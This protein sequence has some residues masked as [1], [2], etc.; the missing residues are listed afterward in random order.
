[1]NVLELYQQWL[2]KTENNP[3]IYDELLAVKDDEKAI[4]DRFYKGLAFGTGGLRGVIGAGT[5][6]MN[7]Y[8]VGKA[9]LG[10]ADY[11]LENANGKSVGVAIAY[12]S[13]NMSKEFAY[14]AAQILS[15]KGIKAYLFAELTPTPVLSFAVRY[16]KADAGI[17]I[18]ASH[19]PKEY[20]GYKVYNELGCQITDGAA[21]AI[22]ACIEKH[23]YFDEYTPNESL[24]VYL[25][26]DV[27]R[28]FLDAIKA[29][30]ISEITAEN[31]PSVVYSPLHGTGR[32]Y[33]QAILKELG[34]TS[35][36][37]VAEQEEP[38]GNFTT[39]PY[40]NPE[41]KAALTL[42]LRDAEIYKPDL[43]MA[44]DPDADRIGIAV[45]N[46]KGEYVLL[47]GN[48]TGSILLYYILSRKREMG[49]LGATPTVI[50]TIV[51]TDI[52]FDMAKEF[53]AEV[54]E[55]LTGF[56]YIGEALENTDNYVLGL[57]ES[58]GYLVGTHARDKDA[59]SA[60]MLIVEACAYFKG[61]GKSLFAVLNEIYEKYGYYRTDLFSISLPGKD[62]MEKM[63]EMLVKIRK[64][65]EKAF[66]GKD[67][68]FAD[69]AKGLFGLPKSDVLRFVNDTY[70]VLIRPSGTEPK[71]KV[72]LQV[73]GNSPADADEKLARIRT[74]VK[75]DWIGV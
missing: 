46:E 71:M 2:K 41:E 11:L 60:A 74:A 51:T 68:T 37:T 56:K 43:V 73:K 59:V 12:D 54:K 63:Q 55:V 5:N 70:R 52:V 53:S 32:K 50:K 22:T 14:L 69:F 29:F 21:K 23:G 33:V 36:H 25:G 30:S 58:Y 10:L 24:I 62:G 8:S 45:A 3:Q 49:T 28:A 75:T 19:N 66:D 13:R 17:V 1:M 20:N 61:K 47:N 16:L 72:Y 9:T 64:N 15:A 44:T 4:E 65:P 39:C 26:E 42:A 27:K 6:R 34:V 18:T 57:E 67:F 35:L 38:D 40:P 48:E 7:V 31:L